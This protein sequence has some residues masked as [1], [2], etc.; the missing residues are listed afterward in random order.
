MG[1]GFR[2]QPARREQDGFRLCET[3]HTHLL[4]LLSV[5]QLLLL[6]SG[7]IAVKVESGLQVGLDRLFSL[8]KGVPYRDSNPCK[9]CQDVRLVLGEG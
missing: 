4:L 9:T 8:E 3:D 6:R 2:R 5:Q 7:L 1:Q